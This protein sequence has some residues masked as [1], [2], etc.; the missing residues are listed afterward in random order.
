MEKRIYQIYCQLLKKHGEPVKFWP[1]WCAKEKSPRDRE[2][3]ALGAILTQ[4]TSWHNA[5]LALRNLKKA[6]LLSIGK[7]AGLGS[8][9]KLTEFIRPAGFYKTKPKRL[10]GFCQFIVKEYSGLE[11]FAK[12]DLKIAREKLLGLFGIGPETADTILCYGLDKPSFV[13]DEYTRRLA[14]K[15]KLAVNLGYDFLKK[16]FEKSLPKNAKLYRDF[17]ALIIIGQKGEEGSRM[18]P[19]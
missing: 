9:K 1:N 7:I 16:L 14:R 3:I 18:E 19:F 11:N 10:F 4:H 5:D 2:I 6:K 17:H 15:E 12:E 8:L 13:I